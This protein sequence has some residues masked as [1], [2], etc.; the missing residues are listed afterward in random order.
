MFANREEA[1]VRLAEKL[2]DYRDDASTVILA[3]P[4]G[5]VAV[6][7]RL[8]LELHVPLDVLITRKI[9]APG[10]PE[11][12]LGAICETGALFWNEEAVHA[13]SLTS[14]DLDSAARAQTEEIARRVALYRQN[15]PLPPVTDRNIILVDDGIAT[16][17]TFFASAAALRQL[18]PR[19]LIAAIPIGPQSTIRDLSGR[20]DRL[21]VL[22]T[23]EPFYAVGN[24]YHDFKQLE[25]RDVL[26]Y[27]RQAHEAALTRSSSG[28]PPV[29]GF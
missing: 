18:R 9:G 4:R 2:S 24:F 19:T 21:A 14:R 10:N 17:A 13:F 5:G 1:G 15:R 25:D 11:Y 7:Y 3:L 16:G 29:G 12:A 8:S 23:P 26:E 28:K 27:L 20:V 22:G 6:G